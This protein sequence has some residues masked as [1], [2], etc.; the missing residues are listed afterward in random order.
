MVSILIWDGFGR[1]AVTALFL[2]I[3]NSF[4]YAQEGVPEYK[5]QAEERRSL[6]K[7]EH[8]T[9]FCMDFDL[10]VE[11]LKVKVGKKSVVV[12]R[13]A[14]IICNS[15]GRARAYFTCRPDSVPKSGDLDVWCE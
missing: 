9:I 1:A 6:N 13:N 4:A 12:Q 14:T 5:F 7:G 2:T 3:L 11:E 10:K 8:W 15:E